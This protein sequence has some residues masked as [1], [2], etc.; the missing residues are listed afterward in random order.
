MLYKMVS[1]RTM[2]KAAIASVQL[3]RFDSLRE[4]GAGVDPAAWTADTPD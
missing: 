3:A 2:T 1:S 4:P